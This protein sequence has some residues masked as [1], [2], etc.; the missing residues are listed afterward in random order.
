MT[1]ETVPAVYDCMIY[2]QGMVNPK[3]PAGECIKRFLDGH[4][5]LFASDIVFSEAR[6]VAL[7]PCV[8]QKFGITERKR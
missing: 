7:R 6:D 3:G 1:N 5:E 4:V 2:L 8:A